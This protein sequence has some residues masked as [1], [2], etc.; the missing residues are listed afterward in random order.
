MPR[1]ASARLLPL[2]VRERLGSF[3][4]PS[5]Q[6]FAWTNRDRDRD[7]ICRASGRAEL[8]A[9]EPSKGSHGGGMIP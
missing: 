1:I 9:E 3:D 2:A 5:L 6:R 7:R 4:R 8:R